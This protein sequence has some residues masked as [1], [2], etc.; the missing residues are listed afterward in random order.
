MNAVIDYLPSPL[1]SHSSKLLSCFGN[2][3]CARAFKV[4]HDNM[5]KPVTFFRIYHGNL[6]KVGLIF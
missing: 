1:E 2:N 6:T 5:G 4:R 3:L